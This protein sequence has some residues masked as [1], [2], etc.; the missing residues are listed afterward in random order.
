MDQVMS[1]IA[2]FFEEWE[3]VKAS[4][5]TPA[6]AYFARFLELLARHGV[7]FVL[8]MVRFVKLLAD[9]RELM[10][11][12]VMRML[13]T[14]IVDRTDAV[15]LRLS[16][17]LVDLHLARRAHEG[18]TEQASAEYVTRLLVQWESL[19][20]PLAALLD[21]RQSGGAVAAADGDSGATAAEGDEVPAAEKKTRNLEHTLN[22]RKKEKKRR[23]QSPVRVV[24]CCVVLCCVVCVHA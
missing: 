17:A 8:E 18:E 24:L 16:L 20:D 6:S 12:D 5:A 1:V 4:S 7:R 19:L 22:L 10:G 3:A 9:V 11:A 2:P 23:A 15:F 14:L 13:T 21:A